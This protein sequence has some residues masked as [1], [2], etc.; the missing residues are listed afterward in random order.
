MFPG[1]HITFLPL[2]LIHVE[3]WMTYNSSPIIF[4]SLLPLINCVV[5]ENMSTNNILLLERADKAE[6]DRLKRKGTY[7]NRVSFYSMFSIFVN[8]EKSLDHQ[9][10]EGPPKQNLTQGPKM[11]ETG[12]VLHFHSRYQ[13]SKRS[14]LC[15]HSF[16]CVF[17]SCWR[18][19]YY[20]HR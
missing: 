20:C 5:C 12:P 19:L 9:G 7:S 4:T 17:N 11:A 8:V 1:T 14:F 16:L 10:M 2:R 3:S 18:E 6:L 13:H 15:L